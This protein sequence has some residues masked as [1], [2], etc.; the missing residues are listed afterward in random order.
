MQTTDITGPEFYHTYFHSGRI[1]TS[2]DPDAGNRWRYRNTRVDELTVAGR[3]ELDQAQQRRIYDEVQAIVADE[4]PVVPLWHEDNVVVANRTV[5][6][7]QIVPNA[8]L[9]GLITTTK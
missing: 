9:V 4:V 1:P 8:R 5:R 3:G 6:G 7:Y 2:K